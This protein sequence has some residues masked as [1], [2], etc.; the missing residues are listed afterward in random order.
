[1]FPVFARSRQRSQMAV[2]TSNLRQ[3][4]VAL[5]LYAEEYGSGEKAYPNY[6]QLPVALKNAPVCDGSDTWHNPC[7][8][9]TS[10]EPMIGSYAYVRGTLPWTDPQKWEEWIQA[11][12]RFGIMASLFFSS[13]RIESFSGTM[14]TMSELRRKPGAY[15]MPDKVLFLYNDGSVSLMHFPDPRAKTNVPIASWY[16]IFYRSATYA[17]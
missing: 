12:P 2:A 3:C 11:N 1:M 10:K 17:N 8:A 13:H 5:N 16:P 9:Q 7:S 6:A 14:P 4:W 15:V